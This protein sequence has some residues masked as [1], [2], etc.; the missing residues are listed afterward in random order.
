[1]FGPIIPWERMHNTFLLTKPKVLDQRAGWECLAEGQLAIGW[2]VWKER[3]WRSLRPEFAPLPSG[4]ATLL[5][6]LGPD[7]L[8]SAFQD[9]LFFKS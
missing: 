4:L 6:P 9:I 3:I 8:P 1:M 5:R 2:A 7:N